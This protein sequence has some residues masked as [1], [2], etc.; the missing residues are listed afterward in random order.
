MASK[1]NTWQQRVP[2]GRGIVNRSV[3]ADGADELIADVRGICVGKKE[4]VEGRERI[5]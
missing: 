1:V 3:S 2:Y 4:E 5:C